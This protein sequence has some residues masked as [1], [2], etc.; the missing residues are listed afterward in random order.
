MPPCESRMRRTAFVVDGFNVYH[1]LRDAGRDLCGAGTRWL[2]LR[3]LCRSFL[4]QIHP[5]AQL[6]GVY[7]FS[8]FA[9]HLEPIKPG[10]TARHLA[11]I[12]CLSATGVEA[13]MGHFK[14]KAIPCASCGARTARHEEKETDVAIAVRLVELADGD[15][16]DAV[17]LVSGDSDLAPALRAVARHSPHKPVYCFF[18]YGR[19][20]LDLRALATR[21]F[22]IRKERYAAHQLPD[23]VTLPSG[24]TIRRPVGW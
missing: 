15:T 10:V 21:S 17:A 14:P 6:S 12:E 2:D 13:E 16:C 4:P 19:G 20:S 22:K 24:H 9:A 23:P 7:Y 18:P 11:Y 8:A 3:S 5:T 1:S